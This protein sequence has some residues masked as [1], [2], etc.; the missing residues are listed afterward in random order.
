MT[1]GS[2]H[3]NYFY[4]KRINPCFKANNLDRG[5]GLVISILVIY[6]FAVN[7]FIPIRKGCLRRTKIKPKNASV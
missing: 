5:C 7:K 1:P 3:V 6:K 4:L 2:N